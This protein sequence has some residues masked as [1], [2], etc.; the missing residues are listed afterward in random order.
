MAEGMMGGG[1]MGQASQQ[2]PEMNRILNRMSDL[3]RDQ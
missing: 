2:M 3:L 1:M